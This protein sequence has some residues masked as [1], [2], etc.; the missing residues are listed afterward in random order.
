VLRIDLEA[1]DAFRGLPS[2]VF[3]SSVAVTVA[4]LGAAVGVGVASLVDTRSLEL[5]LAGEDRW[6]VTREEVAAVQNLSLAADA[7]FAVG[8]VLAIT[9]LVL[10][11]LT[12][13]SSG[14]PDQARPGASVR[15]GRIEAWF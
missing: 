7:M 4:T 13:W 12:S 2:E 9:S 3:W 14:A 6:S 5:R 15:S 11:L 10:G 1:I 8:G